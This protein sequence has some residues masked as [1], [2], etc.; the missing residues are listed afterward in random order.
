[1]SE[2][3]IECRAPSKV[4]ESRFCPLPLTDEGKSIVAQLQP[5]RFL[6]CCSPDLQRVFSVQQKRGALLSFFGWISFRLNKKT[7]EDLPFFSRFGLG[8]EAVR[9]R[10]MR[11]FRTSSR[12][13]TY[14][15]TRAVFARPRCGSSFKVHSKALR[16]EQRSISRDF[17]RTWTPCCLLPEE[18]E[19]H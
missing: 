4:Q 2:E 10:Y 11:R 18:R 9:P 16:Q 12:H 14:V 17:W 13:Q 15:E 6:F 5:G 3:H 7:T 1:M 8:G 19:V